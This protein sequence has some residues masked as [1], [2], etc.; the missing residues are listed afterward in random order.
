MVTSRQDKIISQWDGADLLV[1]FFCFVFAKKKT[2][3]GFF[4]TLYFINNLKLLPAVAEKRDAFGE[5][6]Q[7]RLIFL[8]LKR[9][10]LVR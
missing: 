4:W 8:R 10:L 1:S 2:G 3:R 9:S 7:R 6:N 5:V